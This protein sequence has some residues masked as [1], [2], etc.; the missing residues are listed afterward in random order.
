MVLVDYD[1]SPVFAI[2]TTFLD[3]IEIDPVGLFNSYNPLESI[4]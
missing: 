2:Q 1:T 4:Y 3:S